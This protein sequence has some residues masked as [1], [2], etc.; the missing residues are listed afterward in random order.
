[1]YE[2]IQQAL[3]KFEFKNENRVIVVITDAKAK[4]IGRAN[5]ELNTITAKKKNVNIEI[6]SAKEMRDE[7]SDDYLNFLNF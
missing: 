3:E 2:A 7:D 6:I 5:L 1:M 4:V